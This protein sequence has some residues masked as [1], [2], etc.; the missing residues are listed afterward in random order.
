MLVEQNGQGFEDGT[1]AFLDIA[2]VADGLDLIEEIGI[3]RINAHVNRHTE[4]FIDGLIDRKSR[5]GRP[6]VKVYGPGSLGERGATVAFN[7]M[8]KSGDFIPFAQVVERARNEGVSFRGGCFCNPGASEKAFGFPADATG[9]CLSAARVSGFSIDRFA[10]CLGRDIA[11]GAVR[12][13][14]GIPTNDRDVDRALSIVSS[15]GR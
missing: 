13:S 10:E 6:L 9:K 5:S 3:E 11:V 12:A 14:F 15:L 8:G 7:I 4:R 1:P 2:A